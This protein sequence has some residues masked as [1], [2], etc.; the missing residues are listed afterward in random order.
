MKKS[1]NFSITLIFAFTIMLLLAVDAR[2][3]GEYD[4]HH[5]GGRGLENA[6]RG[7]WVY[8]P[9]CG[10]NFHGPPGYGMGP[11]MMEPGYGGGPG[12]FGGPGHRQYRPPLEKEEVREMLENMIRTSRNPNLKV[13]RIDDAGA[14]FEAEIVTKG[15]ESLVDRVLVDKHTARLRSAY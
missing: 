9:Y 5:R 4:M 15:S 14:Y 8:C 12:Y 13:G 3:Q 10:R 7:D 2:A 1:C 6:P 11:G